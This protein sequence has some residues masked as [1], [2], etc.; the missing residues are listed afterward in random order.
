M[1]FN[2]KMGLI[3]THAHLTYKGLAESL[4]EVLARSSQAGVTK[5]I[6]IGTDAEHN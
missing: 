4:D 1:P 2:E 5:C 6:A 3:D